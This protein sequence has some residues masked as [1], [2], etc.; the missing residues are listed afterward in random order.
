MPIYM[1]DGTDNN[2]AYVLDHDVFDLYKNQYIQFTSSNNNYIRLT[3]STVTGNNIRTI[4]L[5][6]A[7]GKVAVSATAPVTLPGKDGRT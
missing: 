3:P 2:L 1:Q 7:G 5:P 6:D 4:T